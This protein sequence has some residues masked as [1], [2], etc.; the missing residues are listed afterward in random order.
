MESQNLVSLISKLDTLVQRF[1][2]ALGGSAIFDAPQ[3]VANGP[4]SAQLNQVV[5][6]SSV[7]SESV[8]AATPLQKV[9]PLLTDFDKEIISKIKAMEDAATAL[10]GDVVPVIT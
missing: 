9:H 10:G 5:Q 1:E 6:A 3:M 7:Q 8:Q 4:L 2:S